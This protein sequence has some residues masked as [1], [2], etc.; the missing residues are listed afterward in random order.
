MSIEMTM[1]F[2][3]MVSWSAVY[4]DF[5]LAEKNAR[6]ET[7]EEKILAMKSMRSGFEKMVA[8]LA[9]HAGITDDMVRQVKCQMNK[10]DNCVNLYGRILAL[11]AYGVID[12]ESG[13]NYNTIRV[14]G[15]QGVHDN[16]Y[17]NASTQQVSKD[18]EMMYRLLHRET[19]LFANKYMKTMPVLRESGA[20]K[21]A[22]KRGGL[23]AFIAVACLAMYVLF[24]GTAMKE[25]RENYEENAQRMYEDYQESVQRMQEQHQEAVDNMYEKQQEMTQKYQEGAKERYQES[26]QEMQAQQEENL[27]RMMGY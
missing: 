17:L 23:V 5:R 12:A 24:V 9:E 13:K 18:M 2:N 3:H 7:K 27:R 4:A 20:M 16:V 10:D 8:I 25:Q 22:K 6:R 11:C 15:N 26:V 14:L 21:P 1:N 19:N